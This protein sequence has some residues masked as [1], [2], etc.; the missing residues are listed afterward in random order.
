M[1]KK[2]RIHKDKFFSSADSEVITAFMEYRS[3]QSRLKKRMSVDEMRKQRIKHKLAVKEKNLK[4]HTEKTYFATYATSEK[5][6]KSDDWLNLRFQALQKLGNKCVSC[7][8]TPQQGAVLH[9]DHIRPRSIYP[10]LAFKIE[11]LQILCLH[12]NFGK[13]TNSTR[14]QVRKSKKNLLVGLFVDSLDITSDV[15]LRTIRRRL[16]ND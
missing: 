13:G 9:V 16:R 15:S 14:V 5:F 1:N 11:N 2:G 3:Q 6:Y 7:G 12:C 8:A 4:E 10:E